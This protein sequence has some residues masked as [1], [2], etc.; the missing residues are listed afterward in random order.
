[1]ATSTSK[2]KTTK[3]KEVKSDVPLIKCTHCGKEAFTPTE[4]KNDFYKSSSN[5]YDATYDHR[6]TVCKDCIL[7]LYKNYFLKTEDIEMAMKCTC[8]LLDFYYDDEILIASKREGKENDTVPMQTLAKNVNSL[9]QYK[10]KTFDTQMFASL[11][12]KKPDVKSIIRQKEE[13]IKEKK[14]IEKQKLKFD[15][16]DFEEVITED[17]LQNK[18]E[19]EELL[20]HD[21]FLGFDNAGRKFLY[22]ALLPYLDD[23]TLDDP[24]KITAIKQI[25]I[26]ENQI[27]FMDRI[28]ANYKADQN[29][30]MNH[31]DEIDKLTKMKN[32]ISAN[33]DKLSKENSIAVKHRKGDKAGKSGLGDKMR[34]YREKGFDDAIVSYYDQL[35]SVGYKHASDISVS[36]ILKQINLDEKDTQDIIN[37]Q[38][39]LIHEKD[40]KILDLEEEIRLLHIKL[41]QED[42]DIDD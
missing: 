34:I 3:K 40:D 31:L 16:S 17:D 5:L 25:L 39:T 14:R 37:R 38:R 20:G 24:Y 18:K 8:R 2:R 27:R 6:L 28:I 1:M 10:R 33:N 32:N 30:F 15:N 7:E 36:S 41:S 23:E 12:E 13:E 21:P 4:A 19:V 29:T 11:T 22:A 35:K 9:P 26:N 42:G